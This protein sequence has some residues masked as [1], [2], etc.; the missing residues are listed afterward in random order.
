MKIIIHNS[1]KENSLNQGKVDLPHT[2]NNQIEE[3]WKD[4]NTKRD[5]LFNGTLLRFISLK[6]SNNTIEIHTVSDVEYK[7]L[8][9]L[10]KLGIKENTYQV[11]SVYILVESSDG[12]Y[13]YTKRDAGDWDIALDMSGGFIQ[14]RHNIKDIA[15]F[16]YHRLHEDL[17]LESSDISSLEFLGFND[18]KNILELMSVYKV[19]LN[20]SLEDL[21]KKYTQKVYEIPAQYDFRKHDE[22]FD[23]KLHRP[24]FEL[25]DCKGEKQL[26]NHGE[27]KL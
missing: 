21:K 18:A 3:V 1:E 22:F 20:I 16:V 9:G 13:F 17:R 12:K 27:I 24:L 23:I 7:E 26:C 15:D 8:V 11:L 19:K 4:L 6:T 2:V 14:Q 5:N 10:R 25:F